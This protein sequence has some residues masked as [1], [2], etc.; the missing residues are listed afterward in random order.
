[1]SS[2]IIDNWCMQ[3]SLL[4]FIDYPISMD[5]DEMNALYDL[6]TALVLWDEIYYSF[7]V[8]SMIWHSVAY[9]LLDY[10]KPLPQD[11]GWTKIISKTDLMAQMNSQGYPPIV[12]E[13]ALRYLLMSNYYHTNY[14]PAP[15]RSEF[16]VKESVCQEIFNRKL[17][18]GYVDQ[19]VSAKY[20]EIYSAFGNKS[21]HFPIPL[22]ANYIVKNARS[23]QDMFAI[24]LEIRQTKEARQFRKWLDELDASINAGN[25][26]EMKHL[27][28]TVSFLINEL[29]RLVDCRENAKI[30][31]TIG[32]T[33]SIT[34]PVPLPFQNKEKHIH[35]SFLKNLIQFGLTERA[36]VFF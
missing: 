14:L 19:Q 4:R 9:G 25:I 26:L 30:E 35:T 18:M 12:A 34:V 11:E 32:I 21:L 7:G 3:L 10:L 29:E 24:A 28:N 1:M 17:L 36:P 22:L 20:N 2:V 6:L 31:M 13:G 8:D 27:M 23:Q 15:R 5:D 33:P 16:L